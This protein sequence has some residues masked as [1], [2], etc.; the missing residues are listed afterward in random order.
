MTWREYE[1]LDSHSGFAARFLFGFFAKLGFCGFRFGNRSVREERRNRR[2][3]SS[4][5]MSDFTWLHGNGNSATRYVCWTRRRAKKFEQIARRSE[6]QSAKRGEHFR[7]KCLLV[8]KFPRIQNPVRIEHFFELA[9]KF[10]DG[11][12]CC[13]RPPALLRETDPVLARDHAAPGQNLRE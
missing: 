8:N 11:L 10:A 6:P 2:K 4:N 3:Q 1:R 9:M 7:R 5:S 13:L 12:A